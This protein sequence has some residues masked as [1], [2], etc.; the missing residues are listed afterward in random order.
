MAFV[1]SVVSDASMYYFMKCIIQVCAGSQ[2][3]YTNTNELLAK[4]NCI[5]IDIGI[6]T[7]KQNWF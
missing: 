7:E 5:G 3:I 6:P 4:I 1:H 2:F